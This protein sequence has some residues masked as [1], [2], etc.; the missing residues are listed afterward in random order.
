MNF[1]GYA[2]LVLAL[3]IKYI[4]DIQEY[5]YINFL[6]LQERNSPLYKVNVNCGKMQLFWLLVFN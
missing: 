2:Y 1:R 4:I 3:L 5:N 6:T